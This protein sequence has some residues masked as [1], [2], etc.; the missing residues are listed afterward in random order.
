MNTKKNNLRDDE[1]AVSPVIGVILMVAITV[2]MAAVIG[3]FVYG[4]GGSMVQTKDVA[5][6]ARH[7]GDSI[8][9]TFMGGPDQAL[10]LDLTATINGTG[11]QFPFST[12]AVGC[13]ASDT[14][15]VS[16]TNNHI[17][18]VAEFSDDTSGV[19][20]DTYC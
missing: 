10:V 8:D 15:S 20:L 5:C 13:I 17:V 3:A 2:V 18:V 12:I 7:V 9:V 4:Y 11:M 6:V 16:G 19:I 1:R 14:D